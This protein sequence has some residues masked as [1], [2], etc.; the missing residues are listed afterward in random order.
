M[1]LSELARRT[2]IS[3]PAVHG[4]LGTLCDAGLIRPKRSSRKWRYYVLTR[5]GERVRNQLSEAI[6]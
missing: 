3:K 2:G 5:R 6:Y 4:H 1:Y